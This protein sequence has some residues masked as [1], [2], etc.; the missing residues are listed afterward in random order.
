[1]KRIRLIFI[2]F[3]MAL[4]A[5]AGAFEVEGYAAA[6]STTYD[7]VPEASTSGLSLRTKMNFYGGDNRGVFVNVNARGISLLA[8]DILVG[9]AWRTSG[10]WFFE[11]GPGFATSAIFGSGLGV[12]AGTGVRLNPKWFVNFPIVLS[13][14]GAI[15]WSPYI[16]YV[17]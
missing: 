12:M 5:G 11:I 1:M 9:Y 4:P 7:N 16:G 2:F 15:F 6:N 14:S 3:A 8:S 17:F 10:D 13:T